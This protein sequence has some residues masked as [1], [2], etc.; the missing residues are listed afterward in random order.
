MTLLV[1]EGLCK[2]YSSSGRKVTTA[3][4]DVSFSLDAGEVVALLGRSGSGK[5]TLLN[6]LAG[7][8]SP[9]AGR[10]VVEGKNLAAIG[11]SGRTLLRR[12]RIGFVF[13]FFN[14][15]PTLTVIENVLLALELAG[16]R[17]RSRAVEALRDVGLDGLEERYP[18][19]LSGGEQQ[20]VAVARALVKSPALVLADEATGNLDTATGERVLDLL[21][22]RSRQAGTA[23]I[24]ASH[25][26][27]TM[28]FADRVLRIVD[29]TLREER[30]PGRLP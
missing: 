7:L 3:L 29:G 18:H 19:E 26:P 24:L 9:T 12:R 25:A 28:H 30:H 17:D 5:T 20:R 1:A 10:I 13:Q 11:E 4:R 16:E 23:L 21:T 14:L 15:L 2:S 22:G 6:L 8:D 27:R